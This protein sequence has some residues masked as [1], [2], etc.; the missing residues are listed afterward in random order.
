MALT[1]YFVNIMQYNGMEFS[2]YNTHTH[3]LSIHDFKQL[4]PSMSEHK[5]SFIYFI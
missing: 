2:N 1:S 5:T 4:S 3:S